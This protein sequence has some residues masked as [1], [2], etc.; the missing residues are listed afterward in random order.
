METLAIP[1]DLAVTASCT[2]AMAR[3]RHLP[4]EFLQLLLMLIAVTALALV[5]QVGLLLAL[6]LFVYL[7]MRYTGADIKEAM[8]IVVSAKL[9]ALGLLVLIGAEWGGGPMTLIL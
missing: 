1:L 2:W 8:L 7:L 4:A 6:W 3:L 9:S 5:P